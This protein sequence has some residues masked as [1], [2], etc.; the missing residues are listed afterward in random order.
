MTLAHLCSEDIREI[1]KTICGIYQKHEKN[2]LLWK[3]SMSSQRAVKHL[4]NW[5]VRERRS[6]VPDIAR[7][8]EV[9]M[10]IMRKLAYATRKIWS[11]VVKS[12]KLLWNMADVSN[13]KLRSRMRSYHR[14]QPIIHTLHLWQAEKLRTTWIKEN[15]SEAI[16][17]KETYIRTPSRRKITLLCLWHLRSRIWRRI[18]FVCTEGIQKIQN[19]VTCDYLDGKLNVA[20]EPTT[21]GFVLTRPFKWCIDGYEIMDMKTIECQIRKAPHMLSIIS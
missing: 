7:K 21:V 6:F 12:I 15:F 1:R 2:E 18:V 8:Y 3:S 9:I 11:S 20:H 13:P 19:I 14:V 17:I 16:N 10:T 5:R 4:K